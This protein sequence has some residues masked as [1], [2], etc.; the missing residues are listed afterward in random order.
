MKLSFK[1]T[2]SAALLTLA[3][4]VLAQTTVPQWGQCG[5]IGWTGPTVCAAGFTC[6]CSGSPWY[7]NCLVPNTAAPP[8]ACPTSWY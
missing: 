1:A 2:A 8:P 3:P 7:W 4:Y 6:I 5:G